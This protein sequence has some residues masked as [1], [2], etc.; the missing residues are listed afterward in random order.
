MRGMKLSLFLILNNII[1][2]TDVDLTD[3]EL[4]FNR[5]RNFRIR[6]DTVVIGRI[7]NIK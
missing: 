3:N 2:Y 5:P 4:L 6:I 1:N 7:S